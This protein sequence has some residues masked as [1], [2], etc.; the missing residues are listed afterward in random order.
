[1]YN[2]T[3]FTRAEITEL[4]ELIESIPLSPG[5]RQWPTVPGLRR[6]LTATL[7]YMRRNRVQAEIAEDYGVSQPTISRAISA[8]T[9]LLVRAL[10]GF[11]PTADDRMITPF[12]KPKHRGVFAREKEFNRDVARFDGSSSRSSPT[13]RPG[14]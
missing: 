11:V 10:S 7:T 6:A 5:M 2:I 3:G 1:M 14:G 4:C 12:R 13:S 8:I 9:P